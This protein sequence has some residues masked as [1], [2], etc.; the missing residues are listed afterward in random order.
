MAQSGYEYQ[1]IDWT[2]RWVIDKV[3]DYLIPLAAAAVSATLV[4]YF[5]SR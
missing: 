1:K 3:L 5:M 4:T 2:R